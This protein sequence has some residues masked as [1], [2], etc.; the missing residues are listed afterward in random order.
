MELINGGGS[1]AKGSVG[2]PTAAG[3]PPPP[4][5][6]KKLVQLRLDPEMKDEVIALARSD[7]RSM[8]FWLV[9][10]HRGEDRAGAQRREVT[11]VKVG[12]TLV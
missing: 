8:H 1:V 3:V 7:Q 9:K 4:E 6:K 11:A 10:R 12:L 5:R 2:E